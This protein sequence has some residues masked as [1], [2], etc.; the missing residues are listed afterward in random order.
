MDL[1]KSLAGSGYDIVNTSMGFD[2]MTGVSAD[3]STHN[4]M[5]KQV[6][7]EMME[8]KAM[9]QKSQEGKMDQVGL[10]PL[11]ASGL[12]SIVHCPCPLVHN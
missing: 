12:W 11:A 7:A 4:S 9:R 10:W 5:Q 3:G 8:M 2:S 1:F 6:K